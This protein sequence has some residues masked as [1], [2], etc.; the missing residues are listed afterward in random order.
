MEKEDKETD[1]YSYSE[2]SAKTEQYESTGKF[3]SERREEQRAV[4]RVKT[5]WRESLLFG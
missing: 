2:T 1:S 3:D 4:T 5:G